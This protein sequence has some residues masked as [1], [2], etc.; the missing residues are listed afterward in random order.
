MAKL[1]IYNL[2]GAV[3]GQVELSDAIFAI[4][5]NEAVLH[6]V[7][8]GQL[9]NL[10]QGTSKTKT[11]SEVRG[12]GRKPYRQKGTGRARQG[13][14]RSAQWVG[15]GVIFGPVPRD[16]RQQLPKKLRRLALKSALSY[17][18]SEENLVV[19]ENFDL[20]EVKT[21]FFVQVL[22]NLKLNDKT[23]LLVSS[24]ANNNLELSARNIKGVKT[25][26]VESISALNIIKFEKF[27]VTRA[28]L[29]K[30]QEVYA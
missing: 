10:R 30:I 21:K 26:R 18:F 20:Q 7:I 16:Y 11:R 22:K 3:T 23:A 13:S 24:E 8:K 5:P 29:E 15:G 2:E 27:V 4:E 12:G 25:S 1:D 28:A 19:V 14:I 17:K 6:Q 9:A